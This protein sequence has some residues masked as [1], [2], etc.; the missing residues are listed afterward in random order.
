MMKE[1]FRSAS[2]AMMKATASAVDTS[3]VFQMGAFS[4][5]LAIFE[6]TEEWGHDDTNY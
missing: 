1:A 2:T 5:S 3:R 4:S 6:A